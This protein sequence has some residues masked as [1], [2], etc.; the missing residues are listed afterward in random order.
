MITILA[1][2]QSNA[3]GNQAGGPDFSSPSVPVWNS[4]GDIDTLVNLGTAW[5]PMQIGQQPF[6]TAGAINNMMAHAANWIEITSGDTVR[7]ILIAMGSQS[8]DKW[9]N[10]SGTRG[11]LYSRMQA[12]L[13]AA[14]VTTPVDVLLWHQGEADNATSGTYAARWSATLSNLTTDGVI[15]G[16]TRI[17]LGETSPSSANVLPVLRSLASASTKVACLSVLPCAADNIHFTGASL[18]ESGRLLAEAAGYSLPGAVS[19]HAVKHTAQS[20][21]GSTYAKV[22]FPA[23]HWDTDGLYDPATSKFKPPAGLYSISAGMYISG[24]TSGQLLSLTVYKNGQL[25]KRSYG[26]ASGTSDSRRLEFTDY[27]SGRDCYEVYAYGV[28]SP[29]VATA[30]EDTWFAATKL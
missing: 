30:I 4:Q 26:R 24:V 15:D 29:V 18:S 20:L 25:F 8:I 5:V 12:V 22:T 21:S 16:G 27:A 2:G 10:S 7:L 6:N 14:G 28:G 3:L 11:A 17:A 9:T 23:V 1:M 19:F 13:A